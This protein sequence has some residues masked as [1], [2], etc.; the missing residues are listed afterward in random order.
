MDGPTCCVGAR[1]INSY[2]EA[3]AKARAIDTAL[4]L[5]FVSPDPTKPGRLSP[6]RPRK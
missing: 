6:A 2:S 1:Y 3:R 5:V 4:I